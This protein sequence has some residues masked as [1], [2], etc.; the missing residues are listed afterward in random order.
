MIVCD[1]ISL[2]LDIANV[3]TREHM[4]RGK[5]DGWRHPGGGGK[6]L[7]GGGAECLVMGEGEGDGGGLLWVRGKGEGGR[8]LQVCVC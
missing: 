5:G 4:L 3:A 7:E 8:G 1:A 6:G 2:L